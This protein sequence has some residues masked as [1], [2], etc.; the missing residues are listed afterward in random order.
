MVS[1]EDN[2]II[3]KCNIKDLEVLIES[4]LLKFILYFDK[5]FGWFIF[6]F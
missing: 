2:I 4:M 6:F 5:V 3:S 1:K